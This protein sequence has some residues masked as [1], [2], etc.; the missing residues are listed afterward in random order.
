MSFINER[1][2]GVIELENAASVD[3][4]WF[5]GWMK[6]LM[7]EDIKLQK[8]VYIHQWPVPSAQRGNYQMN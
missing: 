1:S 3:Q 8:G 2:N 6:I 7:A 4:Q 5:S